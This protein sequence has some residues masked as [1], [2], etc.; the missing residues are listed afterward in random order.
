M[1][2]AIRMPDLGTTV[3][4]IELVAWLVKEGDRIKRGDVIAE[5]KTDKAAS[6]LESVAEGVVL[7][8]VVALGTAATKG[9]VLAYVGAAGRGV[10]GLSRSR[11]RRG[12]RYRAFGPADAG[13]REGGADLADGPEPGREAGR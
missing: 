13:G 12:G 3:E 5:I 4:E 6:E 7:K 8:L 10:A 2:I 1:A 11:F 9:D